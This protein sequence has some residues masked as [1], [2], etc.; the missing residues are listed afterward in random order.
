MKN[1]KSNSRPTHSVYVVEGE[2][3]KSFWTKVGAAWQHAD[4]EG[5]NISLS[6][7]PLNGRLVVRTPKAAEQATDGKAGQ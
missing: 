6:A 5:L 1:P 4:G 7:I 2:G 3:E